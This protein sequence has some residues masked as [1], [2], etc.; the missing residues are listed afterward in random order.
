MTELTMEERA[1][2]AA[3]VMTL[4][5]SAPKTLIEP[6]SL[7]AADFIRAVYAHVLPADVHWTEALSPEYWQHVATKFSPGTRVEVYSDDRQI[8]FEM[9][10]LQVAERSIPIRVDAAF[11]AIYP[12]DLPLPRGALRRFSR[13]NILALPTN[14][15]AIVDKQ[16][17][18]S[19]VKRFPTRAAAG[20]ALAFIEQEA[21]RFAT[22][23]LLAPEAGAAL[24]LE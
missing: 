9:I 12:A 21:E 6:R 18:D 2:Q 1:A 22:E 5:P 17:G 16:A 14:E 23:R 7:L 13:F 15:Y 24:A 3:K 11:R 4:E 8:A 19:I 20:D 10:V